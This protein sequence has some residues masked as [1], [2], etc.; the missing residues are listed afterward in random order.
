MWFVRRRPCPWGTEVAWTMIRPRVVQRHCDSRQS[1]Y[2]FWYGSNPS[3]PVN[4]GLVGARYLCR[5]ESAAWVLT[6]ADA[7][8]LV[9]V[10]RLLYRLLANLARLAARSGRSKDRKL[11]VLRHQNAVL[12]RQVARPALTDDD[13]TLLGAIAAVLTKGLRQGWIVTPRRCCDGTASESPSTGPSLP[14][15]V[16]GG[17]PSML[18][19][20]S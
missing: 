4:S 10:F 14:P 13:R 7:A 1:T 20:A 9:V 19:C 11:I 12:R 16:S 2:R 3:L 5:P 17:H 8:I 18:S 6:R 15:D